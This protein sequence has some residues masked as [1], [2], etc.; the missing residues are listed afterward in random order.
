[1]ANRRRRAFLRRFG[2]GILSI[3]LAP[4]FGV[5]GVVLGVYL[6]GQT[7]SALAKQ[8]RVAKAVAD[9]L[10]PSHGP[11][12]VEVAEAISLFKVLAFSVFAEG[13]T[14]RHLAALRDH[15]AQVGA[16][17]GCWNRL[18]ETCRDIWTRQ[19]VILR[20]G[21]GLDDVSPAVVRAT[22]EPTFQRIDDNLRRTQAK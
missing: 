6:T 11:Y 10:S 7:Q 9:M 20:Q 16:P 19:V 1:M 8:E 2:P 18:D 21:V 22:L 17:E 4:L 5:G 15:G 12:P 13:Q 3:V 14:L